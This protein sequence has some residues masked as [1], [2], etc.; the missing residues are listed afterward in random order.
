[1]YIETREIMKVKWRARK[2]KI[3]MKVSRQQDTSIY[4]VVRLE[5]YLHVVTSQ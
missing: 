3:A 1:M 4:S 2:N 5:A